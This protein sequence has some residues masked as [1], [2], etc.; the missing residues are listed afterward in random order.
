MENDTQ[1]SQLVP[2]PV[3]PELVYQLTET[4]WEAVE[5]VYSMAEAQ[6][7]AMFQ[8]LMRC[9]GFKA[10]FGYDRENKRLVRQGGQ[11]K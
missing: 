2:Q 6:A 7:N 5:Q 1:Q 8:M 9:R 11:K 4:E 10:P 3:E